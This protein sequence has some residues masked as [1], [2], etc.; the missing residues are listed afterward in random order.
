MTSLDKV[1]KQFLSKPQTFAIKKKLLLFH[2]LIEKEFPEDLNTFRKHLLEIITQKKYGIN[3]PTLRNLISRCASSS[4]QKSS[5]GIFSFI[6]SLLSIITS[7]KSQNSVMNA[8]SII[9]ILSQQYGKQ[10]MSLY[11]QTIGILTKSLKNSQDSLRSLILETIISCINGARGTSEQLSKELFKGLKSLS[12]DRNNYVKIRLSR[13]I[14]TLICN[15]QSITKAK[16]KKNILLLCKISNGSDQNVREEISKDFGILIN[17]IWE[18]ISYF[19][20]LDSENNQNSNGNEKNENE[21]VIGYQNNN[22]LNSN[23][24]SKKK[25]KKGKKTKKMKMMMMNRT[26][27]LGKK[28][29]FDLLTIDFKKQINTNL[30]NNSNNLEN[31]NV[32]VQG[33][34]YFFDKLHNKEIIKNLNFFFDYFYQ[35]WKNKNCNNLKK[36]ILYYLLQKI[37]CSVDESNQL[38]ILNYIMNKLNNKN[39]NNQN[40]KN[41]NNKKSSI[42][43]NNTA[44][45]NSNY[46][47]TA[48]GTTSTGSTSTG[49]TTSSSKKNVSKK[50]TKKKTEKQNDYEKSNNDQDD[51]SEK[52]GEFYLLIFEDLILTLGETIKPQIKNVID[53]IVK[54]CNNGSFLVRTRI[55]KLI[56]SL[57]KF[58]NQ[59]LPT[60]YEEYYNLIAKILNQSL[61]KES[62][63]LLDS[64]CL[65][66]CEIIEGLSNIPGTDFSEYYSVRSLLLAQSLFFYSRPDKKKKTYSDNIFLFRS[67]FSILHTCIISFPRYWKYDSKPLYELWNYCFKYSKK[68]SYSKDSL[69]IDLKLYLIIVFGIF[70]T[71]T[72]LLKSM[73]RDFKKKSNRLNQTW[74]YCFSIIQ[75]IGIN[76][77]QL[78]LI[79]EK[80]GF[81]TYQS[82]TGN[83]SNKDIASNKGN[84]RNKQSM[85]KIKRKNSSKREIIIPT[86]ILNKFSLQIEKI[87]IFLFQIFSILPLSKFKKM[88]T[89]ILKF[90][91]YFLHNYQDR[92]L[93]LSDELFKF[94]ENNKNF[95]L[96]DNNCLIT[97]DN[98]INLGTKNGFN[99]NE[100]FKFMDRIELPKSKLDPL[101]I[102]SSIA[103]FT[104]TFLEYNQTNRNHLFKWIY[105]LLQ[106][107]ISKQSKKK[108]I[109]LNIL[110]LL[111]NLFKNLMKRAKSLSNNK[112][113]INGI[114]SLWNEI[115]NILE[116]IFQNFDLQISK[117]YFKFIEYISFFFKNEN[118]FIK[119]LHSL[120]R[121]FEKSLNKNNIILEIY[122]IFI[123]TILFSIGLNQSKLI[124]KDPIQT[125]FNKCKIN[126]YNLLINCYQ[127]LQILIGSNLNNMDLNLVLRYSIE[128]IIILLNNDNFY[129]NLKTVRELINYIYI[130]FEK[131]SKNNIQIN[132]SNSQILLILFN[133]LHSS[134]FE[135]I[136]FNSFIFISNICNEEI[137]YEFLLNLILNLQNRN[138][139][140]FPNSLS[141]C[142][143]LL[144]KGIN[145]FDVGFSENVNN[146]NSNNNNNNNNNVNNEDNNKINYNS[147]TNLIKNYNLINLNSIRFILIDFVDYIYSQ[148]ITKK[149]EKKFSTMLKQIELLLEKMINISF[150]IGFFDWFEMCK[151]ILLFSNKNNQL[152]LKKNINQ[153]TNSNNIENNEN[154]EKTDDDEDDDDDDVD[155]DDDYNVSEKNID[156]KKKHQSINKKL[157]ENEY[158]KIRL[159]FEIS[160]RWKTKKFIIIIVQKLI[161]NLMNSNQF[162]KKRRKKLL[163]ILQE[164]I[165]I[166]FKTSISNIINFR[167]EGLNTLK[168]LVRCFKN[169]KDPEY[170]G[171]FILEAY[172][173][174]LISSLNQVFE[175]KLLSNKKNTSNNNYNNEDDDDDDDDDEGDEF[176][177][178]DIINKNKK[179]DEI[180]ILNDILIIN[181]NKIIGNCCE[182]ALEIVQFYQLLK[183]N[184]IFES[185]EVLNQLT[186]EIIKFFEKIY[187]NDER[188]NSK[189]KFKLIILLCN[190]LNFIYQINKNDINNYV[191]KK[192]LSSFYSLMISIL[193]KYFSSF[194]MTINNSMYFSRIEHTDDI[195]DVLNRS[196]FKV[197][198]CICFL[199]KNYYLQSNNDSN[200]EKTQNEVIKKSILISSAILL[201]KLNNL[202][203][204]SN[205]NI[206]NNLNLFLYNFSND[207]NTFFPNL[208]L[209]F[210]K[211]LCKFLLNPDFDFKIQFNSIKS[212]N[213]LTR[214]IDIKLNSNSN[215]IFDYLLEFTNHFLN[216][217]VIQK[218]NNNKEKNS[219]N[220]DNNNNSISN[221][222]FQIIEI[223]SSFYIKFEFST[224]IKYLF[225][226]FQL[227]E[228][229]SNSIELDS[230][231]S[232]ILIQLLSRK[233]EDSK[234]IQTWNSYLINNLIYYISKLEKNY[235][236]FVIQIIFS[237]CQ[238]FNNSIYFK[239][240]TQLIQKPLLS[241]L[242][243]S[244]HEGKKIIISNLLS[245]IQSS[246]NINSSNS[247]AFHLFNYLI[248]DIIYLI[249]GGN[250]QTS[251]NDIKLISLK[252][253]ISGLAVF[254]NQYNH[255]Q[256]KTILNVFIQSSLF[257]F[258]NNNVNQNQIAIKTEFELQLS[259][260][261]VY[262]TKEYSQLIKEIIQEMN[263][264]TKTNFQTLLKISMSQNQNNNPQNS[265]NKNKN[266]ESGNSNLKN[267]KFNVNT[268]KQSN[269]VS[270]LG[271]SF[272]DKFIKQVGNKSD[273]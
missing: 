113:S 31:L 21:N 256:S 170:K 54:Y 47:T 6:Q 212:L 207:F 69:G 220:N 236:T 245:L 202:N 121:Q 251:N 72:T 163:K 119:L 4:F 172:E 90:S 217:N 191:P 244:N 132:R 64:Y 30:N 188:K 208:L 157:K 85:E 26:E 210:L 33:I 50:R 171:H 240:I 160:P 246:M 27:N 38:I 73:Q 149:N 209:E 141:I 211:I 105:E 176:K 237:Y 234:N 92:T 60:L 164:M 49:S 67:G 1:W 5:T 242:I 77:T 82:E 48:T 124:I 213:L 144:L 239:N 125:I 270:Q 53:K 81:L 260:F 78:K 86:I 197:F 62:H 229:Y 159:L 130:L 266:N 45:F 166:S 226:I 243:N 19:E 194:A 46:N 131:L 102:Q 114:K 107:K 201:F 167:K 177:N 14:V 18:Y 235:S 161:I 143:K 89:K 151:N 190:C 200:D 135:T 271:F 199:K 136:K 146:N 120:Q 206:F 95:S 13:C 44:N 249:W 241:S 10:T 88:Q 35:I 100:S 179:D 134:R 20:K 58:D 29:L 193:E 127:T 232:K 265:L 108:K 247:I 16:M 156:N 153:S 111:I 84:T 17:E 123:K 216:V 55:S 138:L 182:F 264:Q 115:K 36:Q 255:L 223:I 61:T 15:S 99:E 189:T 103:L 80:I 112:E 165:E 154:D 137:K 66:I 70:K 75:K 257:C 51:E 101:L 126:N 174:Q 106:I 59:L 168:L 228:K 145:F 104:N 122:P 65:I 9:S 250:N 192:W 152:N 96:P 203:N 231:C 261:L 42:N 238:I 178:N 129:T 71:V 118:S 94:Y 74:E 57:A 195:N 3:G 34:C 140:F 180:K 68:I 25:K 37:T 218:E 225:K 169:I 258:F 8:L 128:N 184:D 185:F 12:N 52:E 142:L 162:V 268:L 227:I 2:L 204:D 221:L 158:I 133:L 173:N 272:T 215:L 22:N 41:K 83:R 147:N 253:S 222:F 267:K 56:S 7:N 262:I 219:N 150:K 248:S 214:S 259:K 87:Y 196:W 28:E 252:C 40:N 23:L 32:I 109:I 24:D 198:N 183:N 155:D 110:Y 254:K 93:E 11:P 187:L 117:L 43:T 139:I 98:L 181:I 148:I 224:Q 76:L 205:L 97:L 116:L 269:K 186:N 233:I 230:N 79:S 273:K 39:Q 91:L 175:I 263:N 63:Y